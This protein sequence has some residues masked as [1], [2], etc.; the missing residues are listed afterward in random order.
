MEYYNIE[1]IHWW[2]LSLDNVQLEMY[3]GRPS[4]GA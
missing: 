3:E 2:G 1:G 4:V